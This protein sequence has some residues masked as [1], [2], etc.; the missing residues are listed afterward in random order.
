M[1]ANWAF[2]KFLYLLAA[3]PF[4]ILAFYRLFLGKLNKNLIPQN[5]SMKVNELDYSYN[6]FGE[7]KWHL[8]GFAKGEAQ[9]FI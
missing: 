8:A 1:K 5:K 3:S 4:D 6:A 7:A 9:L 2:A